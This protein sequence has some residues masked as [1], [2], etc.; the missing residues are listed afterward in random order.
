MMD[1]FFAT[2]KARDLSLGRMRSYRLQVG[3]HLLRAC[4]VEVVYG[5]I[6]AR[7]RPFAMSCGI[8][9]R[10][11]DWCGE[12]CAAARTPDSGRG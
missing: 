8:R 7:G 12:A 11:Q 10:P 2:L 5:R 9:T 6:G 1:S 3:T 4:L